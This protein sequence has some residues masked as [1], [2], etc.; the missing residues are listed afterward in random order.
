MSEREDVTKE[1]YD[2][3]YERFTDYILHVNVENPPICDPASADVNNGVAVHGQE[4]DSDGKYPWYFSFEGRA[5]AVRIIR[6][7]AKDMWIR[8]VGDQLSIRY[9]QHDGSDPSECTITRADLWQEVRQFVEPM[10]SA[11][12]EE[13][14]KVQS[15]SDIPL[16]LGESED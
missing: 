1:L 4:A 2:E 15:I 5:T 8:A 10:F 11:P 3:L 14:R 16:R 7:D 12:S 9:V 6:P 13:E